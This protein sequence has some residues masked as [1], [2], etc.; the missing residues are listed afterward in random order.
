MDYEAGNQDDFSFKS[1]TELITKKAYK[2]MM[3]LKNLYNFNLPSSDMI[4]INCQYIRS[5]VDQAAVVWH[6]NLT[7]GEQ[8]DIENK[9]SFNEDYTRR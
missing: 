9:K 3:I 5:V 8:L 4:E 1:N 2:R 7:K 6:S